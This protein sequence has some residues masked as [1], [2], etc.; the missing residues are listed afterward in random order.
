LAPEADAVLL[1]GGACSWGTGGG[2][3]HGTSTLVPDGIR[4]CR[5]LYQWRRALW[6]QVSSSH[7]I[8]P[9]RLLVMSS[10][11]G[12]TAPD[13]VDNPVREFRSHQVRRG[14]LTSRSV[15]PSSLD[16]HRQHESDGIGALVAHHPNAGAPAAHGERLPESFREYNPAPPA[17][18]TQIRIGVPAGR[19][20][21]LSAHPRED[22]GSPGGA[23]RD[24]RRTISSAVPGLRPTCAPQSLNMA[25]Q[26]G[27]TT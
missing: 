12:F 23:G 22:A 10:T 3:G 11:S 1:P 18:L 2:D 8:V 15:M 6:R 19:L 20:S 13:F 5:G 27:S 24:C 16:T 9:G 21:F 26:A 17:L 14:S 7:S 25:A 4:S